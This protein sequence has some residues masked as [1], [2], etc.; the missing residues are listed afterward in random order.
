MKVSE[1]ADEIFIFD[2][3]AV[4]R[5]DVQTMS[6]QSASTPINRLWVLSLS[7][8][9]VDHCQIDCRSLLMLNQ[10]EVWRRHLCKPSLE[11]AAAGALLKQ[12]TVIPT[13]RHINKQS[14]YYWKSSLNTTMPFLLI[15]F[16]NLC[17]CNYAL[18]G[19]E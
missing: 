1:C 15:Q 4:K 11:T 13:R 17:L 6:R 3:A 2:C 5:H 9:I 7:L 10:N 19:I 12:R 14:F 8:I 18:F 16:R